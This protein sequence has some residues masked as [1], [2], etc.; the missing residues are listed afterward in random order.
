M[1]TMNMGTGTNCITVCISDLQ[2]FNEKVLAQKAEAQK[3]Y[4]ERQRKIQEA[5][6]QQLVQEQ[7]A[8]QQQQPSPQ[9][10]PIFI[11]NIINL[12]MYHILIC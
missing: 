12:H 5:K 9:T 4:Q 8:Q 11:V 1:F 6:R 10:V 7:R 2:I 3:E